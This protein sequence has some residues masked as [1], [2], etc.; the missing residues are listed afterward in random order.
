MSLQ[1][2][3]DYLDEGAAEAE[4]PFS[5]RLLRQWRYR[6]CGPPYLKI[7]HLVRYRRADLEVW[8][9]SKTVTPEG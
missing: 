2:Q 7:G 6:R 8:L 5:R 4:F 9:A 1:G 3:H